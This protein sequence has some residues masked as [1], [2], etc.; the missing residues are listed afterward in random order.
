M[1]LINENYY[2]NRRTKILK[3]LLSLKVFN[4]AQTSKKWYQ[5]TPLRSDLALFFGDLRQSEKLS[6][7]KPALT[8]KLLFRNPSDQSISKVQV[9]D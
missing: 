5:I 1:Y 9:Q 4:L 3:V 2:P 6:E 8:L 7:I